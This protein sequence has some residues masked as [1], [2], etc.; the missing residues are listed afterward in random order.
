MADSRSGRT[1]RLVAGW[2]LLV[3]GVAALVLPGPGLLLLAGGLAVLS[4]QYDWARKRLGP[5]RNK[6]FDLAAASVRSRAAIAFTAFLAVVVGCAGVAWGIKPAAPSWWPISTR[7]WL[8]GGWGTGSSL[9]G[10]AVIAVGLLAYSYR[11]FRPAAQS[12]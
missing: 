3:L 12:E 11:R 1:A 5:V 4:Q 6:A 9:I 8:P 2:A 10:S 7:W